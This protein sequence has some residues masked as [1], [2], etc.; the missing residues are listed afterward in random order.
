MAHQWN[1]IGLVSTIVL[2]SLCI[3]FASCDKEQ[4][5]QT[6]QDIY[7][8]VTEPSTGGTANTCVC[9]YMAYGKTQTETYRV[10]SEEYNCTGLQ[11]YL[12][13]DKKYA[14]VSCQPAK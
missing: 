12:K 2:A 6:F 14:G 11:S 7:Q 10:P 4:W 3:C 8:R 9:T 13:N 5:Q 1:K